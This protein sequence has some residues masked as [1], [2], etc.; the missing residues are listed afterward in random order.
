MISQC[1]LYQFIGD[2]SWITKC[3]IRILYGKKIIEWNFQKPSQKN[4]SAVHYDVDFDREAHTLL[5][6]ALGA[7]NSLLLRSLVIKTFFL[8]LDEIISIIKKSNQLEIIKID[9]YPLDICPLWRI[10]GES[11]PQLKSIEIDLTRTSQVLLGFLRSCTQLQEIQL[12]F[13]ALDFQKELNALLSVIGGRLR[14]LVLNHCIYITNDIVKSI[15]DLCPNLQT[16][17]LRG[18]QIDVRSLSYFNGKKS[19]IKNLYCDGLIFGESVF[20]E[21]DLFSQLE[22]FALCSS[23]FET[24]SLS[25]FDLKMPFLRYLNLSGS[26]FSFTNLSKL[27]LGAANLRVLNITNCE[28][29]QEE[30]SEIKNNFIDITIIHNNT[31]SLDT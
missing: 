31:F 23:S 7:I 9:Q 10:L 4:G 3:E 6:M 5:P 26:S 11:C 24:D 14:K 17:N 13:C 12:S 28:I 25:L 16:L 30:I 2:I 22:E 15:S 1:L 21:D 18:C 29:S 8:N 20:L 27:L 19:A